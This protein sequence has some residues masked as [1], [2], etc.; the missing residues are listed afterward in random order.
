MPRWRL[1]TTRPSFR[2]VPGSRATRPR[3]KWRCRWRRAGSSPSCAIGASSR[4]T[5][6]NAAIRDL[7]TALNDRVTRHLGASRRALFDE[8][9]RPALKTAAGRALRLRRM[10]A[11]QGRPR[12]P[13]R[14]RAALLLGA[15]R[16][17]ARDGVGTDH[18]A[19][20]RGLPSRQAGRGAYAIV[21]EPA[22]HDGARAHAVEPPALC[23]LDAGAD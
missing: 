9:E 6:I 8:L 23:R 21:I 20:R 4:S 5:E 18:G 10:E 17:V 14:S 22:A 7:V 3:S 1:T 16:A 19:H 15:A 13:R 2:R 12:L 11:M